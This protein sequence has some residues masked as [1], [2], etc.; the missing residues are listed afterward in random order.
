MQNVVEFKQAKSNEIQWITMMAVTIFHILAVAALFTFSWQNLIAAAVTWWIA[1]SWGIGMGY[2]RLLTHRGFKAPK[3]VEYFL[4]FCGTLGLQSGA[5]N[6]V[7]THRIHHAFTET[8]KDPHSPRDG[9]YWAHM[10]WIF[11]GTAQNQDEATQ[12]RYAPDLMKDKVHIFLSKYYYVTPILAGIILFAI[13]GFSM[14]LWGVFLRQV[15]GWH[16]TWLV[17]SATHLWGTRRFETHDDSRNNGLIAA[18]TFGEGWH[19]NHHANPRSAKHGLAWYE[20][21]ANWLQ[22]KALEKIG[23]AKKVYAYELEKEKVQAEPLREA[24]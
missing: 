2:H 9:T 18:L 3:F 13:G 14:V 16:S 20:F 8:D 5:I 17:N 1:G 22:I 4:T 7:T 11:R 12:W 23:L 6:W 19:N 21:D 24:A 15:I 10:G